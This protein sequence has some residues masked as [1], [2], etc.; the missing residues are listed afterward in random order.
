MDKNIS[1][2]ILVA[3]LAGMP[4][5]S[6]MK[7]ISKGSGFQ[8]QDLTNTASQPAKSSYNSKQRKKSKR[9]GSK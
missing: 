4:E 6:T 8:H 2:A 5:L 7:S 1:M 9:K 3:A